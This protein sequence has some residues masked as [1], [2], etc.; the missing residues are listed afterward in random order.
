[1]HAVLETTAFSRAADALLSRDDRATLIETLA[2]EPLA[3][4]LIPG[5]GGCGG[6]GRLDSF[7][8]E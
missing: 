1:M 3:G 5:L 8:G 7:R 4:D 6:P 2:R